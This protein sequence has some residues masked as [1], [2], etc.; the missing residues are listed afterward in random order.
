MPTPPTRDT[1][2]RVTACLVTAACLVLGVP[3]TGWWW[4]GFVGW[5]PW[6]WAIDGQ[7]PR[8]ALAYGQVAGTAVMFGTAIWMTYLLQRF[9]GLPAVP[10]YLVHLLFALLQGLQW[11][12]VS[13]GLAWLQ[14]R[15]GR[16]VLLL[17]PLVWVAG[18]ALAPHLFP[19]YSALL[20][21]W[22]PEW[23]QVAELG[24]VTMV[25]AVQVA[26]NA[27]LYVVVRD[28]WPGVAGG[29]LHRV[30]L[31]T[32]VVL[33]VGTPLYGAARMSAVDA[34]A[35]AAPHVRFGIV[36]GNHGIREWS[37]K[38]T[39]PAVLFRLQAQSA[40]LE[41]QGAEILV[42][43]ENAYPHRKV[44]PRSGGSDFSALDPQRIRQGFTAP[45]VF[46]TL[47]A[48]EAVSPY[49][50]NT[51]MVLAPDG[52]LGD[53]Y[54]KNYPLLF[55]ESAPLVDPAWYLA[56][57]KGASHINAGVD[58]DALRVGAWR[59]GPLICYEDILPRFA[60]R[61]ANQDVHVL[62]NLTSDTW[63]GR[64]T[65]QGQHLGLAVLRS[66]ETRRA[67]VRAVN[68][69]PSAVID[70][71][72]RVVA[73]TA[74]TD[75]DAKDAPPPVADGLVVDVPM[76][77]PAYRTPFARTGSLFDVLVVLGLVGLVGRGRG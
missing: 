52:T 64:S 19:T 3:D 5:V 32:L 18:E 31:A 76:I 48:D 35:A 15:T 23:L 37:R 25:G 46:G 55:G 73:R 77:D 62:V 54:D 2:L 58:V 24:G 42:W 51:A 26:I 53:H 56:N 36:Q 7:A 39:R 40:V 29:R 49:A 68:A 41:A 17:A 72:G 45:L 4:L 59:L 66:I 67:M 27:A 75:P 47:T 71:A 1:S 30:G 57:V 38:A 43:G 8:R 22:H 63:F 61:V 14:R 9:A 50:W 16:D 12:A 28:A 65:E 34:M 6:L 60:R 13:G 33:L 11:A 74:V 21:C 10:S 70:P 44:L 20:W 69:G